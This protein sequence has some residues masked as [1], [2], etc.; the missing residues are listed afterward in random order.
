MKKL[1]IALLLIS[2]AHLGAITSNMTNRSV[3]TSPLLYKQIDYA[4]RETSFEILPI[5]VRMYDQQHTLSNLILDGK[6]TLTFNQQGKGD[7]NP[8]WFN[9]MSNNTAA[10]YNSSVSFNP[11]N[12]QGG[13]LLHYYEQFKHLFID[14]KSAVMECRSAIEIT[15]TGGG[16]GLN[17]GI[18]NAQ[19]ALTQ[20]DWMYGK[21]GKSNQ[22]A[23]L[24]DIQITLGGTKEIHSLLKSLDVLFSGF[25]LVQAPTGSGTKAEWLFEPQI[26]TNHWGIGFGA[27]TM[28]VNKNNNMEFLIGTNYRYLT[29]AQEVRSFDLTDN[30]QWSR[31]L[32]VQ[33]TYGLPTAPT[34]LSLPGINYMTQQAEI[35]GRSQINL[36]T[37]F[38]KQIDEYSFE[39][40]YNYFYTQAETI[41]EIESR[42]PS[43]GIYTLTGPAGGSGGVSTSSSATINQSTTQSDPIGSPVL[44]TT[45]MFDKSSAA[46]AS[47]STSKL[48]ARVKKTGN[49]FVYGLGASIEIAQSASALST[50]SIWAKFEYLFDTPSENY[51]NNDESEISTNFDISKAK[52][53]QILPKIDPIIDVQSNEI[54]KTPETN[55]SDKIIITPT[56]IDDLNIDND[57]DINFDNEKLGFDVDPIA[58][59]KLTSAPII[60]KEESEDF[61]IQPLSA[62]DIENIAFN[63]D[64]ILPTEDTIAHDLNNNEDNLFF[65]EDEEKSKEGITPEVIA[66][67]AF[68]NSTI[69][70]EDPILLTSSQ[71]SFIIEDQLSSEL[72][73]I[74]K[75][76]VTFDNEISEDDDYQDDEIL[77]IENETNEIFPVDDPLAPLLPDDLED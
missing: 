74:N 26:G 42:L 14:V 58:P 68:E 76:Y 10:N 37:R 70:I 6:S 48:V 7:V 49:S 69:L 60:E 40:S 54:L 20:S 52:T 17:S 32:G 65:I 57:E 44:L 21:I 77:D 4:Q 55:K 38:E 29:P 61:E 15:E 12:S 41:G 25:G 51:N 33:D 13:V 22:V 46:A 23:G 1:S 73:D 63:D 9:L 35:Q 72:D 67:K 34:T 62:E 53:P 47:Y 66:L 45:S 39:L 30:G 28:F 2:N 50:W 71:G 24:D 31:Y 43:Y 16:N 3:T 59:E 5:Y 56:A 27:E 75:E 64:D 11:K 36:Y 8:T 18:L 19:Q